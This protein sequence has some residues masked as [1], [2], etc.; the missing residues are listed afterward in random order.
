MEIRSGFLAVVLCAA[1]LVPAPAFAA[2]GQLSTGSIEFSPTV[3]FSHQNFKREGYGNVETTTRLDIAPTIGYCLSNHY[4]VT[5]AFL[6]RHQSANGMSD[7]ALGASAGL[8]YNFSSQGS[9]TPF[10]GVGFGA[11]FYDGFS[12]DETAVLAPMITG[13]VRV[14]VGSNASV[15][16]SLGYQHESNADGEFQ[17][18][19]NRLVA[20]VGVS[21]FPWRAH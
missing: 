19:A 16:M 7:T 11:L 8:L 17:A 15:N 13:G 10:A 3:S 18:S 6:T 20:G 14:L 21:L 5:A 2:A 12:F 1:T 4:E 9:V